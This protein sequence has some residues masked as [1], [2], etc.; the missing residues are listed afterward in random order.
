MLIDLLRCSRGGQTILE[1]TCVLSANCNKMNWDPKMVV[2]RRRSYVYKAGA[3]RDKL[4]C[5]SGN[6][7]KDGAEYL[8]C[9]SV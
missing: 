2:S 3:N 8:V 7:C 4:I 1:S 9:I 5:Y 6:E